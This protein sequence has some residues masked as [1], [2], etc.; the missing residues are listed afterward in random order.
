MAGKPYQSCLVPYEKEIVTLRRSNPPMPYVKIAEYMRNKHDI[1]VRPETIFYFIKARVK[2][3]K[4]P[5]Y[6]AWDI[7]IDAVIQPVIEP[8][9]VQKQIVQ[10]MPAQVSV[11]LSTETVNEVEKQKEPVRE[12]VKEETVRTVRFASKPLS[13]EE[14]KRKALE[15][16]LKMKLEMEAQKVSDVEK[17]FEQPNPLSR[18]GEVLKCVKNI[19]SSKG[20]F[21][22][23][24]FIPGTDEE[25]A[26]NFD[27]YLLML[28]KLGWNR[29]IVRHIH[30]HTDTAVILKTL[31][32]ICT[33]DSGKGK[34][35][36]SDLGLV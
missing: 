13:L 18:E 22:M 19:I 6:S 31:K 8:P 15:E 14:R 2:G 10:E 34:K 1:N 36:L 23:P 4:Q 16:E 7:N 24:S 26:V 21:E 11:K 33:L 30:S 35:L 20:K 28:D 29:N 17:A 12:P 9:P 27:E 5:K 25:M 3:F 32:A